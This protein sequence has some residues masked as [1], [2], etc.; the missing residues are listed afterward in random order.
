MS[1]QGKIA[2][3]PAALREDLNLRILNNEPAAKI[4]CWLND[5]SAVR[6]SLSQHY[7]SDPITDNNLSNWRQG[8]YAEWL[9][10]RERVAQTQE[11]AKFAADLAKAK[12]GTL[13]DAAAAILAG[14]L[15]GTLEG[16]TEDTG[17]PPA[18]S[19]ADNPGAPAS[20][21]A[22]PSRLAI[23]A[24]AVASL[25]AGDHS[26]EKLRQAEIKLGQA[27]DMIEME[28]QKLQLRLDEYQAKVAAQKAKIE[29][30]LSIAKRGGLTQETLERIEEA[31]KIL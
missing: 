23:L 9:A 28:K 3:L 4:L 30:E 6:E 11:L 19:T 2:R 22:D 24:S 27:A 15:L 13:S 5:L 8:G 12:G 1:R 14:K 17:A 7:A 31:V 18:S 26:A 25:R 16:M 29:G 21:A 10:R 20:S